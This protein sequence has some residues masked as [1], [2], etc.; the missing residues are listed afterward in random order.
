MLN[1]ANII[2][3]GYCDYLLP[4]SQYLQCNYFYPNMEPYLR[5][6]SGRST[7]T[8]GQSDPPQ[9]IDADLFQ[10]SSAIMPRGHQSENGELGTPREPGRSPSH[11]STANRRTSRAPTHPELA[12]AAHLRNYP[13]RAFAPRVGA[14][15][16]QMHMV[17]SAPLSA[18]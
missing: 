17:A 7:G 15:G 11:W 3:V 10:R 14:V 9:G 6:C 8:Y 4:V 13:A 12:G 2:T 1:G 16:A 18:V 5:F